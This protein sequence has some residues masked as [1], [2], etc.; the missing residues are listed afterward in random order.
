MSNNPIVSGSGMAVLI[1]VG[2]ILFAIFSGN[3][4][5]LFGKVILF[6]IGII[7]FLFGLAAS[8]G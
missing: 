8:R 7:V 4:V 5:D 2:C 6:I 1:G 3:S